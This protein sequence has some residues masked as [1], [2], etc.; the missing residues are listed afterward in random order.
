LRP[1]FRIPWGERFHGRG[2]GVG[3]AFDLGNAKA[4]KLMALDD[5]DFEPLW[6]EIGGV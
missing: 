2:K 6:T 4:L 1:K 5:P 3:E